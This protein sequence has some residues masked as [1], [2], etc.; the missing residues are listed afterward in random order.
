VTDRLGRKVDDAAAE[1][2]RAA[3]AKGGRPRRSLRRP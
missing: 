3:L 1:R 2:V